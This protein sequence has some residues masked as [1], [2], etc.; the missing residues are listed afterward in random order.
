MSGKVIDFYSKRPLAATF[1]GIPAST[2]DDTM[3]RKGS[4]KANL[5]LTLNE[6]MRTPRKTKLCVDDRVPVAQYVDKLFREAKLKNSTRQTIEARI[7]A[8]LAGYKLDRLKLDSRLERAVARKKIKRDQCPYLQHYVEIVKTLASVLDIAEHEA[9]YEAFRDTSLMHIGG[10]PAGNEN[11]EFS[12]LLHEVTKQLARSP[13]FDRFFQ[14]L[15]NL[16]GCYDA[17]THRFVPAFKPTFMTIPKTVAPTKPCDIPLAEEFDAMQA[18]YEDEFNTWE[19]SSPLPSTPILEVLCGE[20]TGQLMIER[21]PI[22]EEGMSKEAV[23]EIVS[24]RDGP[25]KIAD[26]Y[27]LTARVALFTQVRLAIGPMSSPDDL[28]P[29]WEVCSRVQVFAEGV[30][31]L[32]TCDR[33]LT[34]L[35]AL[36]EYDLDEFVG[37]CALR[38]SGGWHRVTGL[39]S[40]RW[41]AS[42]TSPRDA[43][44]QSA[45]DST[46]RWLGSETLTPG[47]GLCYDDGVYVKTFVGAS[48]VFPSW[49]SWRPEFCTHWHR[50]N[51]YTV[52]QVVSVLERTDRSQTQNVRFC[53][54]KPGSRKIAF[55]NDSFRFRG[56]ARRLEIAL[57]TGA[58]EE[59][60][61]FSCRRLKEALHRRL[62]EKRSA[63]LEVDAAIRA[64]VSGVILEGDGDENAL[65]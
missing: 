32:L 12:D 55:N 16:P 26:P 48:S 30:D 21:K 61:T 1:D 8:N 57:A 18:S 10:V 11:V 58:I 22:A 54:G 3:L 17:T 13:L 65:R 20:W 50:V 23:A 41:Q 14:E 56:D 42:E 7:P 46:E 25:H 27:P 38:L 29:I 36:A 9:L 35:A 45:G 40:G 43:S 51:G 39:A 4:A 34:P 15:R 24:W 31:R 2:V 64:A 63:V 44:Q 53:H 19:F 6:E 59:D 33:S 5:I 47:I 28:G 60:I 37:T 52:E 49:S 62:D